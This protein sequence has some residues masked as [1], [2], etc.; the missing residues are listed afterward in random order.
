MP[1]LHWCGHVIAR[2]EG[3]AGGLEVLEGAK[4]RLQEGHSL[5][6]FPEGT[7]SPP[8]GL[9]RFELG[10]FHLAIQSGVALQPVAITVEPHVLTG[11]TPWHDLPGCTARYSLEPLEPL[12]V[13]EYTV[14]RR[15]AAELSEKARAQ[16]AGLVQEQ[17]EP[18]KRLSKE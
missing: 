10:A 18:E 2:G 8:S 9:G 5:L 3:L 15:S 14:G 16:L 1:L 6:V 4:E 17:L 7:R 12:P 13:D 11:S